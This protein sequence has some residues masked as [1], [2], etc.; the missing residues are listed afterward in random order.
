MLQLPLRFS[1]YCAE[2][3]LQKTKKCDVVKG[4]IRLF[5]SLKFSFTHT[6]TRT[7]TPRC[8]HHRFVLWRVMHSGWYTVVQTGH[9]S[10]EKYTLFFFGQALLFQNKFFWVQ[11]YMWLWVKPSS[12]C[13]S[14]VTNDCFMSHC[15]RS[16]GGT[17]NAPRFQP[18]K[19][20][21]FSF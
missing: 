10:A 9:L 16:R 5:K 20:H 21:N 11:I 12:H 4:K 17:L 6:H 3:V 2:I 8:C 15:A 7:H 18:V 19:L 1:T 13:F 14:A